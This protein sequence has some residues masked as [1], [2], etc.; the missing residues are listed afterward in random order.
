MRADAVEMAV[1]RSMKKR[2]VGVG[3]GEGEGEGM[4]GRERNG[5]PTNDIFL[6]QRSTG[7]PIWTEYEGRV[8]HIVVPGV[9]FYSQTSEMGCWRFLRTLQGRKI[10]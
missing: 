5:G 9:E 10:Y 6:A 7:V 2:L 4:E 8:G 3:W 1:L